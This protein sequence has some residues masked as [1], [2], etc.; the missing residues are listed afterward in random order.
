MASGQVMPPWR[1]TQRFGL[2]HR[3]ATEPMEQM[4]FA[5]LGL[6]LFTVV[7]F[8]RPGDWI[9]GLAAIPLAKI[10]GALAVAGLVH[11]VLRK[12]SPVS[13]LPLEMVYVFLLFG[14]L[15]IS[16][17]FAIWKGGAFDITS[18]FAKV[19]LVTLAILVTCNSLARLRR[20]L[21]VQTASVVIMALLAALGFGSSLT[22]AIG[23]RMEGVVGGIFGNPNDFALALAMA[24]P[25]VFAFAVRSR[26]LPWRITWLAAMLLIVFIILSTLS[27]GGLLALTAAAGVSFWEFGVKGKRH[28]W[29]LLV[30][31]VGL[32]AVL[33]GDPAS[34][35]QRISTIFNPDED[36]TGSSAQRRQLLDFSLQVTA[37]NPLVG[38]GAGNFP[39]ISGSWLVTHNSYTQL[40]AEAGIPALILF[41]LLG[42][43]TWSNLRR[44]QRLAPEDREVALWAGGTRASLAAFAVGAFFASFA[45]HFLPYFLVGYAGALVQ[46][47]RNKAAVPERPAFKNARAGLRKMMYGMKRTSSSAHLAS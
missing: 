35:S 30:G 39:I 40:S 27:R 31:A 3:A 13:R 36:V 46:I 41:L 23:P 15:C 1:K 4:S 10:I 42:A 8:V 25:F 19:V 33:L 11:S 45:Y 7:Y 12:P 37:D 29:L 18:D 47:A 6:L 9:P 2:V 5:Y 38:I 28:G 16:V 14:Q 17:P 34:Y 43:R 21:Y 22:S 44:A 32:A 20:L 26:N 24:Y